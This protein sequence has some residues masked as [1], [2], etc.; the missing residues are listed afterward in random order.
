MTE[1]DSLLPTDE[2]LDEAIRF[3]AIRD[4]RVLVI[5]SELKYRKSRDD[6]RKP[7]PYLC[8]AE[9]YA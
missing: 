2:Y 8:F 3:H 5:I 4:A 7:K 1:Q 9:G 6:E